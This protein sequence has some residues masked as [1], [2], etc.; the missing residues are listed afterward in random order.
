MS[1]QTPRLTVTQQGAIT[2]VELMDKKILDEA[3]I[4]EI[5]EAIFALVAEVADPRIVVDFVN[6]GHMSSS[7]LG[8]LITLNKRVR[9]K[10]GTLCLCNI[11]PSIY[12]VFVITRLNEVFEICDGRG[13]AVQ[14][15]M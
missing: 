13:E 2:V 11:C 8:M 14:Q 4:A 3:A 9:E 7:M 1:D 15:A 6:V 5:G 12:E 10:G